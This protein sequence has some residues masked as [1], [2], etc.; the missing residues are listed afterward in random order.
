MKRKSNEK[1]VVSHFRMPFFWFLIAK[2]IKLATKGKFSPLSYALPPLKRAKLAT[3][4][5]ISP[6]SY[7]LPF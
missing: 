1:L 5:K 2:K 7:A 6:L 4:S 3:K